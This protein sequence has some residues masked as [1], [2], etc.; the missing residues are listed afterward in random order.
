MIVNSGSPDYEYQIYKRCKDAPMTYADLAHHV[1]VL[2][3][4]LKNTTAYIKDAE[5]DDQIPKREEKREGL[6]LA[7]VGCDKT[8]DEVDRFLNRFTDLQKSKRRIIETWKFIK[9]DTEGMQ[10]KLRNNTELL[11]LSLVSLTRLVNPRMNR[12]SQEMC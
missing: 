8:L 10:T 11:Q 1:Q 5:K 3:Q 6:V 9:K 4:V 2:H 12:F 7:R